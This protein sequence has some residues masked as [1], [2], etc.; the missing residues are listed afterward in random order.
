MRDANHS[1]ATSL[2]QHRPLRPF[3]LYQRQTQRLAGTRIP[4][5]LASNAR[6]SLVELPCL[7]RDAALAG[8]S[9]A[10]APGLQAQLAREQHVAAQLAPGP[11]AAR[12]QRLLG[13]RAVPGLLRLRVFVYATCPWLLAPGFA[14]KRALLR[15]RQTQGN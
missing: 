1:A 14:L 11:L 10:V 7:L 6:H 13:D 15:L 3:S 12:L 2:E 8:V 4:A 5:R 9:A